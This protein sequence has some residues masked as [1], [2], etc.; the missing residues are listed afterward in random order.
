MFTLKNEVLDK[1]LLRR[2][3]ATK[4]ADMELPPRLVQIK[5]VRL[6]PVEE[7][8]YSALYTQTKSSFNDY[9]DGGTLL[10]N[11]AHIFD[12]LIRLRQ[13]R[14]CVY[15]LN[16]NLLHAFMKLANFQ[17]QHQTVDHPYL[18]IHSKKNS[19]EQGTRSQ[20]EQSRL[21]ANGSVDCDICHEPPTDRVVSTCCGAAY[22][23]SCVLDYMAASTGMS[24]S[25]S[26][27]CPS[28]RGAFS[29]DLET[30]QDVEDDSPLCIGSK[31]KNHAASDLGMPSLKELLH[32]A[33]GS[34]LRRIDLAE[35]G[36]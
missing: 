15:R 5:T 27:A 14:E 6:H 32:V 36:M 19:D 16:Y 28:C 3:K 34:I 33:T 22:C 29:I 35:F 1:C 25:T 12:L 18:V 31:T 8:F 20:S 23:R 17:I 21:I 2:T 24:A 26:L 11:Y 30:N 4:A 7:D 10:N 13:V 9:V